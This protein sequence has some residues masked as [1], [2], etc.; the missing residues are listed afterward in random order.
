METRQRAECLF[1]SHSVVSPSH[2]ITSQQR[3]SLSRQ[4]NRVRVDIW[5]HTDT[6]A[7][8]PVTFQIVP[9][10]QQTTAALHIKV[11]HMRMGRDTSA[12]SRLLSCF[13]TCWK[14]WQRFSIFAHVN[15]R[16]L[17]NRN[18][19]CYVRA[20]S[21]LTSSTWPLCNS[22]MFTI[23]DVYSDS[24][25]FFSHAFFESTKKK[26]WDSFPRWDIYLVLCKI[27]RW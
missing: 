12:L 7:T 14:M 26:K 21:F 20:I 15:L 18:T 27:F 11:C 9:C 17:L 8:R 24:F 13:Q 3:F 16:H 22:W 19:F 4:E 10:Q 23:W 2:V 6:H 5:M 1:G 25:F